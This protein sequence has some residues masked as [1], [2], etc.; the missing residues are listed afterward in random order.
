MLNSPR[1]SR[2]VDTVDN[3]VA[4][5]GVI[6]SEAGKSGREGERETTA[7]VREQSHVDVAVCDSMKDV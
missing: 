4:H 2:L 7:A 6:K 1:S 5:G 3:K